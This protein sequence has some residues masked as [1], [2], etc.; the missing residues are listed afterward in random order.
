MTQVVIFH[1]IVLIY[2]TETVHAYIPHKWAK[3]HD[4]LQQTKCI[5]L[6]DINFQSV[7]FTMWTEQSSKETLQ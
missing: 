4:I 7:M 6:Q 3:S 2:L 5:L 1:S